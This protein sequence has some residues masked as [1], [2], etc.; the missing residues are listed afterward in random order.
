MRAEVADHGAQRSRNEHA[1]PVA[2]GRG[3]DEDFSS[4]PAQTRRALL[5]HRAP[6]SGQTSCDERYRVARRPTRSRHSDRRGISAQCPSRGHFRFNPINGHRQAG[7]ACLKGVE[8]RCGA[9]ALGRTYLLPPLSSGG[10]LVVCTE[11]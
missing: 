8:S 7:S 9:V 11:N 4:P 10:A 3:R 1:D 5:T 6:P 2:E